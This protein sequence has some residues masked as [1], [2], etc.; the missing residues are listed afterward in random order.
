[1]LDGIHS[2]PRPMHHERRNR[3]SVGAA[4]ARPRLG[5]SRPAAG[6]RE[7]SRRDGTSV[8]APL[9]EGLSWAS[10]GAISS[11]ELRR[12]PVLLH[13]RL[14]LV[15]SLR[16]SSRTDSP[17]SKLPWRRSRTG[18]ACRLRSGCSAAAAMHAGPVSAF[19]NSVAR[20]VPVGVEHRQQIRHSL[21][22]G[23]HVRQ[24]I[25]EPEAARVHEDE[26]GE[27]HQSR[28]EPPHPRFLPLHFEVRH[29]PGTNRRSG[30]DE[31]DD[32]VRDRGAVVPG[33]RGSWRDPHAN[34]DLDA[35]PGQGCERGRRELPRCERGD[36]NSH[37]LS[38]TGS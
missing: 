32:L 33:V 22:E 6:P 3:R 16:R 14:E 12:S 1:M 23:R 37:G 9:P 8:A 17:R 26:P 10:E 2:V 21:I 38:A 20:S 27:A 13:P 31:P 30:P 19:P 25:G 18:S 35:G 28:E 24:A 4:V 15:P 29:G 34:R 11:I 5:S 7:D 36:S